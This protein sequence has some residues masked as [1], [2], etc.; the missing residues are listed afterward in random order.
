MVAMREQGASLRQ[1]AQVKTGPP[2]GQGETAPFRLIGIEAHSILLS[3]A[4]F[5]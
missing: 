3:L 1:A 5:V 2:A 4:P